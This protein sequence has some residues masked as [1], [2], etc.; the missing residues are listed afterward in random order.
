M[1][2]KKLYMKNHSL[3][4]MTPLQV[5]ERAKY[6]LA[7]EERHQQQFRENRYSILMK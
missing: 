3:S 4:T 7:K 2:V 6:Y 1:A 5:I